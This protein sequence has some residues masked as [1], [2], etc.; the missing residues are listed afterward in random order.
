MRKKV[1]DKRWLIFISFLLIGKLLSAGLI[2]LYKKG[3]IKLTNS[4][5]YGKDTD[6]ESMF[7]RKSK[8][9]T[10][11]ADGSIFISKTFEHSIYKFGPAGK[12][13]K[14]FGREGQGPG[15]LYYPQ[16]LSILDGKYLVIAEYQGNRQISLFDLQGKY[17]K[18]LKT[19]Y[20]AYHPIALKDNKIAY[21]YNG[22]GPGEN[23][24]AKIF[25]K[26]AMSGKEILVDKVSIVKKNSIDV[27]KGRLAYDNY[28]GEIFINRE[29]PYIL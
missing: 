29:N 12:Y 16:N 7:Y 5:G 13:L 14:K 25:I 28:I 18:K 10:G 9:I 21:F 1:C 20:L 26:D 11:S 3:T 2:D 19:E 15:D 8:F 6:W 27:G 4:P 23:R 22:I 24:T 17:I